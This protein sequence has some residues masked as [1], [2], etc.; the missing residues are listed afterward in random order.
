DAL[1]PCSLDGPNFNDCLLK[2][3]QVIFV[4][5]TDGLPGTNT[6]GPVDP[7]FI[8][9]LKLSRSSPKIDNNP[10]NIN[11]DVKNIRVSG[12]SQA[13][14]IDL[15]YDPNQHLVKAV[16]YIPKLRFDSDYKVK[17]NV[18]LLNLNGQGKGFFETE[19]VTAH[20]AVSVKARATPDATFCDV[21]SVKVGFPEIGGFKIKLDNL[22]GGDKQ[23]EEAAH[24]IFNENW[25]QFYEI[26]QPAI[27]E[28][29]QAV[30]LDRTKKI[31]NYVPANYILENFH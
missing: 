27:E 17:G 12:V 19:K 25:R 22:F 23:L 11:V 21:Q 13:K 4:N 14:L 16:L 1:I 9:Q 15:N 5:W 10:I 8:K 6:V 26:L 31:F 29:I 28:A 18:L 24:A 20:L 30:M 7:F 2:N 3:L